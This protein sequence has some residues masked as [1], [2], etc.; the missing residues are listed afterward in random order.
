[1][2]ATT[3][4]EPDFIRRADPFAL[5]SEWLAEATRS[6]INDPNALA[7]ATVD[8]DGMPNV[9]MVLLKGHGEAGFTFFTNFES[10]KGTEIL[11][12]RKAAMCFHWK[13]L[14]RQVRLRGVIEV[15]D[16]AEADAYFASRHPQS[17]LGA[18]VSRQSRALA[19]RAE[20]EAAVE[21]E[22]A[23]FADGTIPRPDH[24]SGFRLVPRSIEFWQD[25]AHRL[26]DRVEFRRDGNGWAGTRLYP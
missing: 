13:S 22:R 10:A 18:R 11:A 9:R 25:G 14:R 20:L 2:D 17:R 5:F 4:T 16:A 7:L 3:L 12:S 26:H 24:W 1:M 19:S 15:V 8:E 23:R 6:E 21:A